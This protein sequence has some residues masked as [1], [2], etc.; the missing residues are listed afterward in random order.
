MNLFNLRLSKQCLNPSCVLITGDRGAGKSTLF[1]LVIREANKQGLKCY[2]QY[3]Y[4]NCYKLPMKKQILNGVERFDI[5][6]EYIYSHDFEDAVILLDEVKTIWPARNY[7]KWSA[8]DE[9]FFNFIRKNNIRLFMATQA[10]DGVDLN[11]RRASDECWYL[12]KG[13]LHF[14]HVEASKTTIAKVADKNTEVMGRMF[15]KGMRKVVWELCEVPIGHYIFW[16]KSFYKD[17]FTYFTYAKKK[18]VI[19]ISWNDDNLFE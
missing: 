7:T 16:R 1:A 8:E 5:D 3:P 2:S 12:T 9:E 18:P 4:K 14:T 13:I 6:K 17:F 10:Y 11:V 15:K 19:P